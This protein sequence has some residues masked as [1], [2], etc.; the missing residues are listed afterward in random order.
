[1]VTR[2]YYQAVLKDARIAEYLVGRGALSPHLLNNKEEFIVEL[3]R[4]EQGQLYGT[5]DAGRVI[6]LDFH[7]GAVQ[8]NVYSSVYTGSQHLADFYFNDC[9]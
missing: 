4:N 5:F 8:L 3:A 7:D 2:A 1:M 6:T 9:N